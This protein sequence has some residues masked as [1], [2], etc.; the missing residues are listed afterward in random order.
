MSIVIELNEIDDALR[1][2][3]TNVS[4]AN[5]VLLVLNGKAVDIADGECRAEAA[6]NIEGRLV[7]LR[8]FA[9]LLVGHLGSILQ[10][11]EDSL[12]E[13]KASEGPGVDWVD[14]RTGLPALKVKR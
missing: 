7:D 6:D 13:E 2:L 1:R 9:N 10:H 11:M 3:R 4:R 8:M 14:A 5:K 12:S